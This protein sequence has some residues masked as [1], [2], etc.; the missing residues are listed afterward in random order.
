MVVTFAAQFG[1]ATI[2]SG[3]SPPLVATEYDLKLTYI[4]LTAKHIAWPDENAKTTAPFVIGVVA[5]D[6]FRGGLQRLQ[7]LKKMKDRPI[8]VVVINTSQ[9][10]QACHIIFISRESKPEIVDEILNRTADQP[11]LIWRDQIDSKDSRGTTCAFI[12]K[13]NIPHEFLI[14]A[15]PAELKRRNLIPNGQLMSLNLIRMA[16]PNSNK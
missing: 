1:F 9:D 16:K 12:P 15:D 13:E 7:Q 8:R 14:Y 10:F 6:P 3:Q 11:V 2:A 4:Y 5:P